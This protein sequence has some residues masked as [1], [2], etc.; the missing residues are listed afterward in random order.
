MCICWLNI[1]EVYRI[2]VILRCGSG[3]LMDIYICMYVYIYIYIICICI[4][5]HTRVC[6]TRWLWSFKGKRKGKVHSIQTTKAQR[7]SMVIALLRGGL[8]S[9]RGLGPTITARGQSIGISI[10][11]LPQTLI[12]SRL[13]QLSRL[14]A[15]IKFFHYS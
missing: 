6:C 1:I 9:T 11:M 7:W 5:T 2:V 13:D 3:W 15:R 10:G 14:G 8:S 12:I 4:H